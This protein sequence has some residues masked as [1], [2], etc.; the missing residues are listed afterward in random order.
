MVFSAEG[1]ILPFIRFL[2]LPKYGKSFFDFNHHEFEFQQFYNNYWNL[3]MI[4]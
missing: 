4:G 1:A 2:L 3:K